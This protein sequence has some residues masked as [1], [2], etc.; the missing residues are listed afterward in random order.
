[1]TYCRGIPRSRDVESC[2]THEPSAT[3]VFGGKPRTCGA[4]CRRMAQPRCRIAGCRLPDIKCG[5]A[6]RWCFS[7]NSI[8]PRERTTEQK[9]V[10]SPDHEWEVLSRHTLARHA[11]TIRLSHFVQIPPGCTP[12]CQLPKKYYQPPCSGMSDQESPRVYWLLLCNANE[13]HTGSSCARV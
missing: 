12:F 6:E 13:D 4:L 1:M 9:G 8:S 7:V 2:R 5:V 10:V 11:M 3:S